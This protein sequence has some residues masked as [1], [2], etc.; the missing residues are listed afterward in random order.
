MTPPVKTLDRTFD[1]SEDGLAATYRIRL[2]ETSD[3]SDCTATADTERILVTSWELH[4]PGLPLDDWME[5]MADAAF[6]ILHGQGASLTLV[7]FFP[8]RQYRIGDR[9]ENTLTFPE[10]ITMA[11]IQ[12]QEDGSIALLD[13]GEMK[14]EEIE[15]RIGEPLSATG[16]I[17][18][19]TTPGETQITSEEVLHG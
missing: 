7:E 8:Q 17:A 9:G 16:A 3:R 15:E 13:F 5:R 2:Y 4:Q 12:P 6:D 10:E 1:L 19:A 11:R 14:R 18:G